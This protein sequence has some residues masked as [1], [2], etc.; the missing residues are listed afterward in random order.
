MITMA[1]N[2]CA[3]LAQL[4]SVS[5]SGSLKLNFS[6]LETLKFQHNMRRDLLGGISHTVVVVPPHV[7]TKTHLRS[8]N[9]SKRADFPLALHSSLTLIPLFC[10]TSPCSAK[11]FG[12]AV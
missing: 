6:L 8:P 11:L 1:D 12:L 3:P 9:L 5:S 7:M 4:L 10:S 2:S